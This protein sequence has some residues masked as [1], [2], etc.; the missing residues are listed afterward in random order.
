MK[1]QKK[2]RKAAKTQDVKITM[3]YD[4]YPHTHTHT[5]THTQIHMVIHT[6]TDIHMGSNKHT[7]THTHTRIGHTL[8]NLGLSR[9][10]PNDVV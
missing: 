8:K 7:H 10:T 2:P 5:H 9:N 4:L 1:R 3:G 6:N